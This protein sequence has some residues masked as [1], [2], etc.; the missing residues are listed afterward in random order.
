MVCDNKEG[1]GRPGSQLR[2]NV[3]LA[4]NTLHL[5]STVPGVAQRTE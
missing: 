3:L 2:Y 5:L 4:V 1:G